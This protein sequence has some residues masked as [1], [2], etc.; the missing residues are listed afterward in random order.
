MKDLATLI[1]DRAKRGEISH[2]S[3][4]ASVDTKGVAQV[5]LASYSPTHQF[6]V[7]TVTDADP[8]VALTKALETPPKSRTRAFTEK[9]NA[10]PV[11]N[12]ESEDDDFG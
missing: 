9:P 5:W 7:V 6:G 8:V 10:K 3:L 4:V 12:F 2:L 11:D 1:R